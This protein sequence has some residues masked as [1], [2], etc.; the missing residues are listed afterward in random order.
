M[1]EYHRLLRQIRERALVR[2]LTP[3]E[4]AEDLNQRFG[5]QLTEDRVRRVVDA[6]PHLVILDVYGEPLK[7]EVPETAFNHPLAYAD[8]DTFAN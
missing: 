5:E 2:H 8:L 7:Y 3:A 4:I 6:L 1:V